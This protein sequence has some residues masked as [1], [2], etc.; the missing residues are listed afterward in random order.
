[1]AAC[2]ISR[3]RVRR[4]MTE[5]AAAGEQ[6]THKRW[7]DHAPSGFGVG[8]IQGWQEVFVSIRSINSICDIIY[9]YEKT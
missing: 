8:T 1:M 7:G 6:Q 9:S 4:P 2:R 5:T 3:R